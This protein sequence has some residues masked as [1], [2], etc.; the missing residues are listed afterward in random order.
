MGVFDQLAAAHQAAGDLTGAIEAAGRRLDLDP[1]DEAGHVR[2]MDL[3]AAMGDRAAAIRQYRAASRPW[4]ASSESRRWS[5]PPHAMRRSATPRS[6]TRRWPP[7]SSPRTRSVVR[8][9]WAWSRSSGPGCSSAGTGSCDRRPTRSKRALRTM[10]QSSPSSARRGSA[11]RHS[12][13]RSRRRSGPAAAWSSAPA[14]IPA[15]APSRTRHSSRRFEASRPDPTAPAVSIRS[16]PR[17][18]PSLPACCRR[19]LRDIGPPR[20]VAMRPAPGSS[21][22]SPTG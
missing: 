20:R 22:R 7:R 8:P 3:Y 2:L 18:A 14:P 5:R 1:L 15:N 13:R 21:P 9:A 10:V 11:K 17:R 6:A 4:S 16:T 19:S 12:A